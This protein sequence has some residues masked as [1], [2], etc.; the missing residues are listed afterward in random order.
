MVD[1]RREFERLDRL[2]EEA[3]RRPV[4]ERS[5]FLE[6]VGRREPALRPA[7]E[8]LVEAAAKDTSILEDAVGLRR[9][10]VQALASE[11][12][13]ALVPGERFGG[14]RV[15]AQLGAG[16][17]GQVYRAR[18][19]RLERDVALKVM[20]PELLED[21]SRR[22]RFEREARLLAALNHPN[23]TAIHQLEEEDGV[24][25]L[26]LELVDGE[27][28]ADRLSNGA[29]PPEEALLF[30][31]QIA[32]ALEAAHSSGVLHRDLKPANV[33]VTSSNHVKVL[34]F[35]L[36]KSLFDRARSEEAPEED[37]TL[38]E[39]TRTGALLG[40][41]PYMSP[42]LLTGREVDHRA[43][44]WAFGCVLFEMS[45]GRRPFQGRSVAELS[46][47][48]LDREPDWSALPEDASP[49]LERLLRGCL[50]KRV[51][52]RPQSAT[53]ILESLAAIDG[54]T[55][56]WP[57]VRR[58]LEQ[59]R[60]A[61][62]D[63]SPSPSPVGPSDE[64]GF[65]HSPGG[66][67]AH[68]SSVG[69]RRAIT[70][71]A[72][73]LGF[74]GLW[75]ASSLFFGRG[76]QEIDS[77]A[78]LPFVNTGG[79]ES[80]HLG[81]G[82]AEMLTHS[83]AGSSDLR[84]VPHSL[85]RRFTGAE[86]DPV[87]A[88]RELGVRAVVT[89]RAEDRRGRL[90]LAAEL[91]DVD[92]V[93]QLW[94]QRFERPMMD[95]VAVQRELAQAVLGALRPGSEPRE[96]EGAHLS[97]LNPE[98]YQLYLKAR[99]LANLHNPESALQ[100]LEYADEAARLAPDFAPAWWA[101]SHAYDNAA[102]LSLL[103]Y[104]EAGLQVRDAG[105]QAVRL[106]P[107]TARGPVE[108]GYYH[109]HYSWDFEASEAQFRRA[110]E[111]EPNDPEALRGL[112]AVLVTLDR[113]ED[114]LGPFQRAV[115][116]E[117]SNSGAI[118][119]LGRC[120]QIRREYSDALAR[121]EEALEINPQRNLGFLVPDTLLLAGRYEEAMAE[122]LRHHEEEG[123]DGDASTR[124]A[125]FLAASGDLRRARETLRLA[126]ER[127][128]H[129]RLKLGAFPEFESATLPELGWDQSAHRARTLAVLGEMDSAFRILQALASERASLFWWN[130]SPQFD[131]F[132]SDPRFVGLMESI[133]LTP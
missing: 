46:V 112:G 62:A 51:E 57:R 59:D 76:A 37:A 110:L 90:V 58:R 47:E 69:P 115:A 70:L 22:Q 133:G 61:P 105:L 71:A 128:P 42:E 78:V 28:L 118:E 106:S 13:A 4:G 132:R 87:E 122:L 82:V 10:G 63:S 44:I 48:I 116:L 55:D 93:A 94:G 73:V 98:A 41:A 30:A 81:D 88:A 43:D 124:V 103:P 99:H 75:L 67:S 129:D 89:G 74:L 119:N 85:T 97:A 91:V 39:M 126:E 92:E 26:V 15:I 29:I 84:V 77:L 127:L 25:A 40:T 31:R 131:V 114:C 64:A 24:L 54:K 95:L 45:C 50:S 19:A 36:A 14:Y 96:P 21:P 9:I 65:D 125:Y 79:E 34:D 17:M 100:S 72:L 33:Q 6:A 111:L 3:L 8:R 5:G 83:L 7:L 56:E 123:R 11:E 68:P 113:G 107:N 80:A 16:A 104:H 1:E 60:A 109:L 18:D 130:V 2:L 86:I 52:D 117:P 27:T 102:N 49:G 35:G 121:F 23:I 101:V 66:Q 120:H 38:T 20:A 32:E 108:L 12:R 53:R